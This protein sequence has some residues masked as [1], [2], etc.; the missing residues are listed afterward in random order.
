[1]LEGRGKI[2]DSC[3]HK[4]VGA[5]VRH[6]DAVWE[7]LDSVRDTRRGGGCDVHIIRADVAAGGAM[8]SPGSTSRRSIVDKDLDASRSDGMCAKIVST[9]VKTCIGGHSCRL[10]V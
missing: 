6:E 8:R 3:K 5:G 7:P 4:I 1:M 10:K 9:S 2:G